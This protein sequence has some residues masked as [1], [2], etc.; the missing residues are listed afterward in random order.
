MAQDSPPFSVLSPRGP[1]PG[2]AGPS[3]PVR[4]PRKP[5]HS[6]VNRPRQGGCAAATSGPGPGWWP[7]GRRP[8]LRSWPPSPGHCLGGQ[9]HHAHPCGSRDLGPRSRSHS[10]ASSARTLL[11]DVLVGRPAVPSVSPL[12]LCRSRDLASVPDVL[13]VRQPRVREGGRPEGGRGPQ[14]RLHVVSGELAPPGRW[15]PRGSCPARRPFHPR[16][17]VSLPDLHLPQQVT[18]IGE[19]PRTPA[20]HPFHLRAPVCALGDRKQRRAGLRDSR[21]S[22]PVPPGVALP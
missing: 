21:P 14:R 18:H 5:W 22:Q 1:P 10:P 9:S 7:R 16:V 19:E 4:P 12:G 15:E 3:V 20:G 11:G 2:R 13:L 17:S 6:A 8:P